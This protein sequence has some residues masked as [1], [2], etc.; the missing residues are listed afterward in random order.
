M[1]DILNTNISSFK[2]NGNKKTISLISCK[3]ETTKHFINKNR[4]IQ[5]N[6]KIKI[7]IKVLDYISIAKILSA[8]SVVILHTNGIFWHFNYKNYS[9]YWI[10]SNAIESIF[11]FAVPV[12]VLCIGATLLDFNEKYGLKDYYYRR[13]LKVILPLFLWSIILYYYRVY[14]LKNLQK[15]KLNFVNIWNLF[16]SSRINSIFS[17]FHHFIITYMIIPLIIWGPFWQDL[18]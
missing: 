1:S 11:Y 5:D 10:S 12:F 3:E 4:K 8:F 2:I 18:F 6:S 7:K 9:K 15:E 14:F 17:S 16:Y 13:F